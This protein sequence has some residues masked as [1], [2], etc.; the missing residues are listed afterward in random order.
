[1]D[2][3]SV[4]YYFTNGI[5]SNY[6][7]VALFFLYLA[8]FTAK[9]VQFSARSKESKRTPAK[10]SLEF[11]LLDNYNSLILFGLMSFPLVVFSKEFVHW[12]GL[13]IIHSDNPMWTYYFIG[14]AFGSAGEWMLKK[15]NLIRN[16]QK[17]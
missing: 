13:N 12:L 2:S 6:F 1:M 17:Q 7:V 11:W 15:L 8:F 4:E 14:L 9:W 5:D 10:V 3:T 16:A